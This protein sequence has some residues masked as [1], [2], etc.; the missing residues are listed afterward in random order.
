MSKRTDTIRNLFAQPSANLLSADN[1][2]PETRRVSAGAVRTM[3]ETF[4]NIE[5]ENEALRAKF[6]DGEHVVEIE[7]LSIDPSPFA[8]R[9]EH[10]D[11]ASFQSLKES[12]AERGQEIP[13]LVRA[14][15][16]MPGRYQTAFG[17]RR[18][19][20][21]RQLGRQVKAIVR[22]LSDDELI[23]AQGIENSAREDLSFIERAV[24]AEMLE[25]TGRSRI[26]IQQALAIDR[27]EASK[28]ISVAKSVPHDLVRAIGKAPKVGRRRWQEFADALNDDAART[29]ALTASASPDFAH[30]DSDARFARALSAVNL[31]ETNKA[32]GPLALAIKDAAGQVLAQ[33]RSNE[34][35]VKV[36]L[37]KSSGTAF[38][39]FL[40]ARLPDLFQ[41]FSSFDR[42]NG[43]PNDS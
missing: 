37:V 16:S 38:A 30:L 43:E 25:S 7:P 6:A 19:R 2:E 1:K 36:T 27:A 35:D 13:I 33:I 18:V 10:D 32:G 9:F 8:D 21:A 23:I 20:A 14:H 17:H 5:N 11:D 3:K 39:K 15:P 24:F 42:E 26:V 41:E 28:L 40:M 22:A 34:R 12:I 31:K 4:S 29:R